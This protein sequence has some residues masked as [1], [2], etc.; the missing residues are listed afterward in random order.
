MTSGPLHC[1]PYTW[2]AEDYALHS[3]A[4]LKWAQEIIGKL[5]L[6]GSES[7]LDI[8]CGDGKITVLL[9]S[10]LPRG[11][12]IG[13]DNSPSMIDLAR[14]SYPRLK[15]PTIGF[16]L[17]DGTRLTFE[18]EFDLVFS[19]TALHWVSDQ[20]AVLRGVE[21]ALKRSGRLFFQMGGR[22]NAQDAI[23]RADAYIEE[24][25]WHRYF[26]GFS[27]PWHFWSP[28]D[29]RTF[30]GK[31]DLV[32][33]RVELIPKDMTQNGKDG[34][35]GWIRTTWLP[36]TRRIP[37]HLRDRFISGLAD[38][39]LHEFPPDDNGLVHVKMVRLEVEAFKP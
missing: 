19:S 16:R 12:I 2:N 26:T 14:K 22:G 37:E 11:R 1:E 24:P 21:Q 33:T 27:F 10:L 32:S 30:L 29:Y 39:Y 31:T 23:D 9:G 38:A 15:N 13:I 4:Q 6:S 36:Y 35:C 28:D 20:V 34:L 25:E 5:N 3:E 7:V 18:N 8:G 17:M